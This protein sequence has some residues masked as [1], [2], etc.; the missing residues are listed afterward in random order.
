[1]N[2]V[3]LWVAL[4]LVI[5]GSFIVLIYYGTEI[6]QKAPPIP[7]KI[8]TTTGEVVFTGADIQEGQNVWQSMGGHESGS[9]WG[10]GSYVAPDWTA[11]WLHREAT[12]I[13]NQ[14]AQET[15]GKEFAALGVEMQASLKAKLQEDVRKNTYDPASGTITISPVR[16]LAIAFVSKHYQSLYMD[17]PALDNLRDAYAIPKNSLKDVE[18]VRKVNAFYFWTAW[19]AVTNRPGELVTY[20]HNWP[21]DELVGNQLTGKLVVWSVISF[22]LLLAGIGLLVWYYNRVNRYSEEVHPIPA[23]DPLLALHP[24][25]SM[26]A[27][28][29][30][31]WVVAALMVVQVLM[32]I[33]TAH[34][35]VEGSGFYG[36]PLAQW[37]PYSITRTWH[38][39]LGIFWI[40]TA[41]LATGLFMAPAVSGFEPKYQ[42]E[43]VNFL[44]ICLLI[45]VVGSL[46]GQYLA[47][48]QKLSLDTNFWLGHQG[49][50]YVDLGR[51]WQIFLLVGL[52]LWLGLMV[53]AMWPAIRVPG[54]HR[55]L[56]GLFLVA[57]AAIAIFYAAGL[58]WGQH[59]N[60]AIAE[61]WRWWVVHLWVE[62]FFEVF[63]TVVIAFLFTR[64]GLVKVTT[65]TATVLFST[66]IFLSGG[67]LGT[68][69]HIYFTGTPTAVIALGASFSALEVVPLVLLGFEGYGNLSLSQTRPWVDAYKWPINCFVAVAFWNF[70]GAGLFGFFINPPVA[71][72]FMQG[73]NT[74]PVHGH[75][76]LFGVYGMLGIGLMLF[77]LKGLATHLVWKTKVL[78]F[79]FWTINIGLALMVLLS[80]LPIG[81]LQTLASVEHGMWYARSAEFMHGPYMNNLRWLRVIGDTI[82]AI[83]TIGLGYFVLGLK[84]GWSLETRNDDR[85]TKVS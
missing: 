23:T 81:F 69:H 54:E 31:F 25:P 56:L 34:Y 39:Q 44:F 80:L 74:T 82:F 38:V 3:R 15:T 53:R 14:W 5:V 36:F 71:L 6:Y 61:Y 28:L 11:D 8:I 17:D 32:G 76:A 43:G 1:M 19:A 16:A 52:F 75:T 48:H 62:G 66:I 72:Y 50:E 27:T 68:F 22:V 4:I 84:T 67:I 46:I 55:H 20:T 13:L 63:S 21:A 47:I 64:M 9:I 41:W 12:W 40:A 18:K 57:S 51:F 85:V 24:T 78:A 42:R 29:K 58:M 33:V 59:T 7:S 10:H 79:S 26:K 73:L 30:Y 83:G 35:G 77:C 60:L 49:Y 45:I 37:I 70:I 65:A 2:Y